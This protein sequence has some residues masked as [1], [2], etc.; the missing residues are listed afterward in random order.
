MDKVKHVLGSACDGWGLEDF[1][2]LR[3]EA[4]RQ[5]RLVH[6]EDVQSTREPSTPYK[7]NPGATRRT[8]RLEERCRG[9]TDDLAQ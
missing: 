2:A 3:N 6:A 7:D 9:A 1:E 8:S 4:K 5:K